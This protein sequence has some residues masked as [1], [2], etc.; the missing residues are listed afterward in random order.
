MIRFDDWQITNENPFLA[1][2]YDNLTRSLDIVGK[3]P[4]GWEWS[5][6]VR[7]GSYLDV[8]D[9]STTET[10]LSAPLSAQNLALQG[11]YSVQLKATQGQQVRHTNIIYVF[12]AGSLSG[13]AQWPDV[14]TEFTQIEQQ[15]QQAN[16]QVQQANQQAQQAAER[17]QTSASEVSESVDSA[18]TSASAAASSAQAAAESAQQAQEAAQ[19]TAAVRSFN[20]RTGEILPQTGDYTAEMV[21]ARPDSWTPTA[22]EIGAV[23]S[24]N[25]R[26]GTV[27]PQAG[28][29]TAEMVGARPDTWTPTAEDVGARP[30]TWMPTAAEIG[31]VASGELG[32]PGGIAPLGEDSK[33]P[34]DYLNPAGGSLLTVTF[35]SSFSGLPYTIA[36]GDESYT[37]TVPES[38]EVVQ[39]LMAAA[40][41]YTL[42]VQDG[43][44]SYT[45]TVETP[46]F[47][48]ALSL[49]IVP[50]SATITVTCPSGSTVTCANGGES[51]T[52]LAVE[53]TAVFVVDSAGTWTVTAQLDGQTASD[54][55][56]ISASGQSETLT[57][58]Y[59]HIYGV[60]WDGT[61][62]TLWSRTDD[63]VDF[64]DPVPYMAGDGSYQSPF[65]SLYP[66]SGMV[67]S[68]DEVAGELVAIP[69]F[70]FRWTQSGNSL[71]LQIA[72][73]E[74]PGFFV[75]PA[76]A[77]R[78]DGAGERDVV[79]IGRY[80]CGGDWTSRTGV[81]PQIGMT[82]S[83][84]RS[85]IH[86]LGSDIWQCDLQMRMTLWM[87]YL[88]EFAD[89]NSE[90]TIGMGCGNN[91]APENM[92][93]T[94]S[95]PY[96]TGTTLSSRD[97]Y[98]L[99]TQYR[100]I[101][102]L[103]DNVM[104]WCDGCYYNT[105]GLNVIMNPS[106]FSDS[107]GGT[108]VGLPAG[109]GVPSAFAVAGISG[110]EWCIYPTS[111]GG[112]ATTYACDYWNYAAASPCLRAG[113]SC[114]QNDLYGMFLINCYPAATTDQALGARLQKLP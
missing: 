17:A 26:T 94:D 25:G 59:Q 92:G 102:G 30:D 48:T 31:A 110:M 64:V 58:I 81:V 77:D 56:E 89:W 32:Q 79:Y 88:V 62:T 23:G 93:Y 22:T 33:I 106:Y 104:D 42:T 111:A 80:H 70:W 99:G 65:D 113:G 84:A 66:W 82:R 27:T 34:G 13:D 52:Q 54:T 78:G 61:S 95:M 72:D 50:F 101:E 75:S 46:D 4:S 35:D 108:A 6:L 21:G 68:T 39:S 18:S 36:G 114:F 15:I 74:T 107:A 41:S 71:K 44:Q 12:V 3:I 7:F 96:H 90:K 20:G 10:G 109:G 5:A 38:L 24:F 97:T 105:S 11:Y 76:H 49:S 45:R 2:Q 43:E 73:R 14:P 51:L 98:G 91:S 86:A 19:Q 112:S 37:G 28:D 103:W 100:N 60:E 16:Q 40:T 55:V 47:F 8:I 9:L 83:A 1:Y 63:S 57:L 87:L 85:G 67:R 69:K 53:G 29:Y